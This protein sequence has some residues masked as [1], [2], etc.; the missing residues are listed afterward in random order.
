MARLPEGFHERLDRS[1]RRA[2]LA[3]SGVLVIT[4]LVELIRAG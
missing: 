2:L 4:V 1:T 3:G